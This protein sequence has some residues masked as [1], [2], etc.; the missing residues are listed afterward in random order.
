[1]PGPAWRA[2][3]GTT[4][5]DRAPMTLREFGFIHVHTRPYIWSTRLG[6]ASHGDK[7]STVVKRAE[8]MP[9]VTPSATPDQQ[10]GIVLGRPLTPVSTAVMPTTLGEAAGSGFWLRARTMA[11]P[12]PAHTRAAVHLPLPAHTRVWAG[13][14]RV[15][16]HQIVD[17][18]KQSQPS[19]QQQHSTSCQTKDPNPVGVSARVWTCCSGQMV[20]MPTR[21]GRQKRPQGSVETIKT[22]LNISQASW[23]IAENAAQAL[24]ISRDAYLEALLARE[25]FDQRGR[26]KWWSKRT[27]PSWWIDPD[28]QQELPLKSA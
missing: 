2:V 13:V 4:W 3:P 6:A 7:G 15:W 16:S 10:Q 22:S 12:I 25:K 1:M 20:C 23:D 5:L 8:S 24:G 28:E 27:A 17:V 9:A 26:P 18:L 21:A 19:D 11:L 14:Q